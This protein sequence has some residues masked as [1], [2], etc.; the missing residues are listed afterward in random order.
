MEAC[1]MKEKCLHL[2]KFETK[3]IGYA[4][5]PYHNIYW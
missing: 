2:L 4:T 5:C 1:C 3:K